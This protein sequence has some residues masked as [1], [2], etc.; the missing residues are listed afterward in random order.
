M[1]DIFKPR[2]HLLRD[3]SGVEPNT[4]LWQRVPKKDE[5]GNLLSDFMML[6]PGLKSRTAT[7]ISKTLDVLSAVLARYQHV[8]VFADMNMRLNVLWISF[9]PTPGVFTELPVAIKEAVPE[10]VLIASHPH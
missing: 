2:K 4:P 3:S 6:I 1:S 7:E 9:R 8:V 5:Q 10:A